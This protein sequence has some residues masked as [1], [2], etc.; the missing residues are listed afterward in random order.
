MYVHILTRVIEGM[1][2]AFLFKKVNVNF[3]LKTEA[4]N[5]NLN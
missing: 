3:R 1:L 2:F 5:Q 4:K